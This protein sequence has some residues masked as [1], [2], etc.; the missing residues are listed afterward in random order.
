M[1]F[2]Q[3]LN[4]HAIIATLALLKQATYIDPKTLSRVLFGFV[5]IVKVIIMFLKALLGEY[6]PL[7]LCN[8]TR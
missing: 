8:G 6:L 5:L 2:T 7:T 3:L 1:A 4:L